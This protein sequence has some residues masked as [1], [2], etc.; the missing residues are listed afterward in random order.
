VRVPYDEGVATR[1]GPE[2]CAGVRE[3]VGE[4]SVGEC[5]GQ[6]LNRE[7]P[8]IP[9]AD[10]VELVEGNTQG[11][12]SAS[13]PGTRRGRRPWHVQTLFVSGNRES[14]GSTARSLAAGP[15]REGEEP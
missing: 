7:S 9:G 13:A 8:F 3:G 4:A 2:P 6:P 15:R 14:S 1:I 5:I 10:T 11:R 12:D